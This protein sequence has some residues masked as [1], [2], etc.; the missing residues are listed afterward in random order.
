MAEQVNEQAAGEAG[1][2]PEEGVDP[3]R[4]RI[5]GEEE[6]VL[7][8]V[9]KHLANREMRRPSTL[10]DYDKELLILRDAINEARLEDIPPL[11]EEMERLQG[12]AAR[13]AEVTESH[14]DPRSPYF[15]RLVLHEGEQRREILIGRGTYL[16]S[17]TGVRIV[18]WRDAPVSRLYYRYEEGD[19]YD[20][21]FGGR[22]VT[23]EVLTRRSLAISEGALR[24]I[25]CPQGIFVKNFQD[26]WLR[27][28]DSARLSGG[29]G[30]APR[31]E[32]HRAPVGRL[33]IGGD[34]QRRTD[35]FLPE[36]AAMIDPR[37]FELITRPSS[38]LVVIQGGAGSGKTTIGLH[39]LAYLAYQEPKRFRRDKMLV[40]VFN[41]ALARYI[42][43]VLPALG[44]EGV[45]VVIYE[46]WVTKLRRDHFPLLAKEVAEETPIAVSRL[47]KSPAM[48][49]LIN[50]RVSELSDRV[51]NTLLGA[52]QAEADRELLR[53]AWQETS[54]QGKQ[55]LS[56]RLEMLSRWAQ[57]EKS[58][59]QPVRRSIQGAVS[60]H[61]RGSADVLSAWSEM[62]TDLPLLRSVF[63]EQP[64]N[65]LSDNEL[66]EAHQW[67]VRRCPQVAHEWDE[68]LE[69]GTRPDQVEPE[70]A[71]REARQDSD[72]EGVELPSGL[73]PGQDS[74]DIGNGDEPDDETTPSD[75]PTL[76][77]HEDETLLLLLHERLRGPLMTPKQR[78]VIEFEHILVDEAQDLS[79]VELS[80]VMSVT[81]PQRSITL[82]GD[83]A[84][85]LH[86]D[87][88]FYGWS[89]VMQQL[90]LSHVEIEPLKLSYRSTYEIIEFAHEV[91]GPLAPEEMG[92]ATRSGAPVELF[93]FAHS[94]DAVGFLAEALRDLSRAEPRASIAVIARYP[95]QA[96]LYC[97]GLINAEVPNVRRVADQDFPFKPGVDVTDVRQVKGLEFDYVVIV[98]CNTATFPT[99][100][101]ARHLM[102][103]AATR[104]AHQLWL[105]CTGEP[106]L[107]IPS[108]LRERG[109]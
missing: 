109:Y 44:V 12:V 76:I 65:D 96:D 45:Q 28:D 27:A 53:R 81:T 52:A 5:V 107:L 17:R 104:A 38:G 23:G 36:I 19:D 37:Q 31:P 9:Q 43:K 7:A 74:D 72:L 50:R 58:L 4:E 21:E 73:R 1:A 51:L 33:G 75:S 90:G 93:R 34:G 39:R 99:S 10:I 54:K 97:R 46:E 35:K 88:G 30:A 106:S 32:H 66:L 100:E 64:N 62:L 91:L 41:K 24:R 94:G 61:S 69:E 87:N 22:E 86:M 95:E 77:D 11:L 15:G 63:A 55:A 26:Q 56:V 71:P 70:E 49:T 108:L 60:R 48:L 68:H 101:E 29:Q 25:G 102:H 42:S 16:D 105:S 98:E 89:D 8:R 79:P 59:A 18:D 14:I 83:V 78:D 57:S 85:R 13:R 80:V 47:K 3:E 2:T 40:V 92:K 84:Q 82:A 103:I 20:E 67:C 6:K